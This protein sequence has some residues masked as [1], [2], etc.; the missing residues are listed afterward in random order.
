MLIVTYVGFALVLR[1]FALVL[2]VFAPVLRVC[3][4]MCP[5]N[6]LHEKREAAAIAKNAR[7][8]ICAR[9]P[10]KRPTSNF[11][12]RNTQGAQI[13]VT[14][15]GPGRKAA[16][17]L[18]KKTDPYQP[19]RNTGRGLRCSAAQRSAGADPRPEAAQ[20]GGCFSTIPLCPVSVLTA[21]FMLLFKKR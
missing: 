5:R 9:S 3:F 1:V 21:A 6:R 7:I 10:E 11:L 18:N 12:L 16:G 14:I 4:R 19:A 13:Y 15:E 17:T 8:Q 20:A 2:R